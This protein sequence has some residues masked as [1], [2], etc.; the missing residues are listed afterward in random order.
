MWERLAEALVGFLDGITPLV[1]ALVIL[2]L[3]VAGL[4]CIIGGQESREKFKK[5]LPWVIG[6]AAIALLAGPIARQIVAGVGDEDYSISGL[7]SFVKVASSVPL[8]K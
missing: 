6:G 3:V 4:G 2:A 5:A 8:L 7:I 1:V